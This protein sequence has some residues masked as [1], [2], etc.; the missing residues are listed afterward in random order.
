MSS[1]SATN[2]KITAPATPTLSIIELPADDA[3]VCT[4]PG[5]RIHAFCPCQVIAKPDWM[6]PVPLDH[7]WNAPIHPQDFCIGNG[8]TWDGPTD[9]SQTPSPELPDLIALTDTDSSDGQSVT[10]WTTNSEAEWEN[11]P[12]WGYKE[13]EDEIVDCTSCTRLLSLLDRMLFLQVQHLV[14]EAWTKDGQRRIRHLADDTGKPLEE[15][16]KGLFV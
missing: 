5:C 7:L 15:F 1:T 6:A 13:K 10:G 8:P 3:L 16:F 14:V 11:S 12:G 2:A 9:R 4:N